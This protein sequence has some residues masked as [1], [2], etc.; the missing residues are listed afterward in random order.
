MKLESAKE[1]LIL[2]LSKWQDGAFSNPWHVQDEAEVIEKNLIGS[3]SL[4]P[5]NELVGL[6]AQIDAVLNQLTNAQFQN[7]LPKDIN[8]MKTLLQA[9]GA[10]IENALKIHF[11][12]WNSID[13]QTRKAE[14]NDYWF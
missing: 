3:K 12:Y 4:K 9:E 14:L 7:V 13:Y 11:Q 8:S 5:Q 6:S 2:L 1:D 10:D